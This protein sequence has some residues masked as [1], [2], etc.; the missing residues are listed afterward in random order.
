MFPLQ[1]YETIN[2]V[3]N[4]YSIDSAVWLIH[5]SSLNVVNHKNI[6]G[7]LKK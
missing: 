3:K 1:K 2:G 4:R 6:Y 7:K 5:V